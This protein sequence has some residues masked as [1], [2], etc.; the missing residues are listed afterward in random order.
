MER[1]T[2]DLAGALLVL[3]LITSQS[4]ELCKQTEVMPSTA[5]MQEEALEAQ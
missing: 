1:I 5:Q 2:E 3:K 4:S